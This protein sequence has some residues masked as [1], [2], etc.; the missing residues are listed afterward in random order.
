M[1]TRNMEMELLDPAAAPTRTDG[2]RGH[3]PLEL[4][5]VEAAPEAH[6]ADLLVVGVFADGT[7]PDAGE[8]LD[9]A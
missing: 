4:R 7:F 6:P 5:V 3:A 1:H 9:R 2:P 8:A